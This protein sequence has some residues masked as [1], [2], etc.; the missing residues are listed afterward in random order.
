M[1]TLGSSVVFLLQESVIVVTENEGSVSIR[2]EVL[3][4]QLLTSSISVVL[5]PRIA[6]ESDNLAPDQ[7]PHARANTCKYQ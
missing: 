1:L 7:L 2:V 3:N 5:T 6:P 4:Q